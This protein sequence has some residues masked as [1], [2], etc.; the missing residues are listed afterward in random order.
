M[1]SQKLLREGV[2][3]ETDL[4]EITP[5]DCAL[6]K[7]P[8]AVAE[9]FQEIPCNPCS[10]YC[11]RGAI[12]FENINDRPIIDYDRCN[13]C[14]LC[15]SKCPGLAIFVI[16]KNFSEEEATVTLPYEFLPLPKKGDVV[17][18]LD[19]YGS[20]VGKGKVVRVQNT[21]YN[22]KTPLIT[23]TV[24]KDMIMNVRNIKVEA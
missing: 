5:P 18:T 7:R 23:V 2:A 4:K 9:C 12:V 1:V 17:T 11:R 8:V 21:R 14:T 22:D 3:D 15:V 20:P 13:G 24:P 16:D 10:T 6:D 19:R